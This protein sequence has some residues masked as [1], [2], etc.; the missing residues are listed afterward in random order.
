MNFSKGLHSVPGLPAWVMPTLAGI[1]SSA[2]VVGSVVLV[3][4]QLGRGQ[5]E[6]VGPASSVVEVLSTTSTEL[7][8]TTTEQ[9]ITTAT[10]T[11][12]VTTKR[13]TTKRTTIPT[14]KPPAIVVEPENVTDDQVKTT[15]TITRAT[16][17][18]QSYKPVRPDRV[19]LED[20]PYLYG[21]TGNLVGIDV[22]RHNLEIDWAAVKAAGIR[23]AVIRCGYRTT[24]G[25]QVYEDANFRKNIQ[26]AIDA[27]IPVGVYFFSAAKTREEALQEAAF[28]LE[29]IK[30]YEITWPVAYDFEIFGQDR[31]AGV[32][33]TVITDN[34]I[35]FM[36]YVAQ[37]GYT[38]AVYSSRNMFRDLWE[39][40]RLSQYRVWLAQ[41]AE[42][43]V[44]SYD[45]PH[46]MWQCA[47]D[48]LVPG[49]N[50]WVD[51]NISYEDFSKPHDIYLPEAPEKTPE[52]FTFAPCYDQ[53]AVSVTTTQLRAQPAEHSANIWS[54]VG[55]GT[56]M[57][58][59]GIDAAKGWDRVEWQGRT[60]YVRSAHLT[61]IAPAPTTTTTTTATTTAVT[62]TA[63]SSQN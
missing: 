31:L 4:W 6:V 15:A 23:F 12:T 53:V 48:G 55:K 49:I 39:T 32:S 7:T 1:T 35:A 37:A 52:G 13:P 14:V 44:K 30:D 62:T 20:L 33:N 56:Q 19:C 51:L 63:N 5:Q 47:S 24:V 2:L 42:L 40:A 3:G 34:A 36:D 41:Y 21:S 26:G 11:T 17:P 28:T 8:T 18:N 29:I 57:V 46:A 45:G 43:T 25:G 59:T 60:L 16:D 50:T 9:T 61:Y 22:S 27:G 38:P 58:R 54:H 10:S